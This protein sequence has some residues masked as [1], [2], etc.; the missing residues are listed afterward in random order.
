MIRYAR[1]FVCF[2]LLAI[3]LSS[4]ASG[5]RTRS[6]LEEGFALPPQRAKSF[7]FWYWINCNLTR[8]GITADLEAMSRVG[9]GGV[10]IGNYGGFAPRGPVEFMTPP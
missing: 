3:L 10:C 6:R 7:T 1:P 9:L 2:M 5:Q 4:A 8:E